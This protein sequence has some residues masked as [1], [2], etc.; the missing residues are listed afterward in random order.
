MSVIRGL[1]R[2]DGSP[3]AGSARTGRWSSSTPNGLWYNFADP[4]EIWMSAGGPKGL[5]AAAKHADCRRSTASARTRDMIGVVRRELDK[6][7]AEAG[8]AP[9]SVKLVAL[10]WFYQLRDR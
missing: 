4:V 7:V 2:G 6:A 9:G 10:S 1:L 8:R 5:A 3:T